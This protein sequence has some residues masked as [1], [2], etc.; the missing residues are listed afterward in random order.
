[1]PDPLLA[2]SEF[3][4]AGLLLCFTP[5]PMTLLAAVTAARCGAIRAVPV[6]IGTG[7]AYGGLLALC[8]VA[9]RGISA[10]GAPPAIGLPLAGAVFLLWI[11]WKIARSGPFDAGAGGPAAA[12]GVLATLGL[13][14]CNPKAWGGCSALAA[15]SL[16][17]AQPHAVAMSALILGAIALAA[18]LSWAACGRI[19]AQALR[20]PRRQ[21]LFNRVA[22]LSL[23]GLALHMAVA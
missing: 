4:A 18:T 8:A 19:A 23:G 7:I 14:L 15:V 10:A 21:V 13:N 20:D 9:L 16:D 22:G 2:L 1:M 12:P 3:V 6:C 5:G 11:A 17:M